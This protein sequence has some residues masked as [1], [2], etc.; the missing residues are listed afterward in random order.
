MRVELY[1]T[2]TELKQ[3]FRKEK[4]LN[5][6]VRIRAVYLALMGKTAPDIGQTL[7]YSRRVIQKWL[8]AYNRCG[9]EGLNENPGR[10]SKARLNNDQ[11]QWL[12]QRI[13]EGPKPED[14]VCV[15]YAADIQRIIKSQFNVDYHVRSVRKILKRL[16]YSWLSSRPEHPKGDPAAREEFKKKSVIR[17]GKSVLI[18]LERD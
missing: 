13:E 12:R 18:I 1:H 15:F 5:R 3:I 7:G 14:G 6:A 8:H 16:G 9:I 2:T 4:N 11:L 17:S 10:G